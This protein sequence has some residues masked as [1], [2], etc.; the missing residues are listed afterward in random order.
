ML[1]RLPDLRDRLIRLLGPRNLRLTTEALDVAATRV[2]RYLLI[3][4]LINGSEG[5]LIAIGPSLI[6]VPN[7]V[8]W[9]ALTAVLRFIPYVGPWIAA[10]MPV[11]LWRSSRN[12]GSGWVR[13]RMRLRQVSRCRYL[14]AVVTLLYLTPPRLAR[15]SAVEHLLDMEV[16]AG[17]IPV[18]PTNLPR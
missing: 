11:A 7:A 4:T 9:G 10:A 12:I 5:V 17:S 13:G 15:S 3:Q 6:G 2:S 1:L 8:L 18:A 16:V 14:A